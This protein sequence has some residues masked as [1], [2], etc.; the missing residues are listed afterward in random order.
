V[1]TVL[2]LI[3]IPV[4]YSFIGGTVD[5]H[6]EEEAEDHGADPAANPD[7]GDNDWLPENLREHRPR[8]ES[9]SA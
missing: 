3:M 7:E 8:P 9:L 1:T 4:A 6:G 2:I 5:P